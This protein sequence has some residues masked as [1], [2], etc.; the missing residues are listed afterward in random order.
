MDLGYIRT[1]LQ[2]LQDVRRVPEAASMTELVTQVMT[3]KEWVPFSLATD[4]GYSRF[5]LALVEP[6][7]DY[8][9]ENLFKPDALFEEE[10]IYL[11]HI[12]KEQLLD[13][14][15][16]TTV[17]VRDN[18]T[19]LDFL[20][21]QRVFRFLF[22]LFVAHLASVPPP[23]MGLVFRSLIPMLQESQLNEVLDR[24]A[25]ADK[26]E[27]YL[28]LVCWEPG[29]SFR[30]DVQYHPILFVD[31]QFLLPISILTQSNYLRNLFASE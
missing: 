8:I 7:F 2:A 15:Y 3:K 12:F 16:L 24:L 10:V 31:Q 27:T 25:P 20:K 28:D 18:L 11:S 19:L 14:H 9:A 26:V 4:F 1:E 13:Y 30:F 22:E 23:S 5:R 6:L 29:L 17:L 21:F